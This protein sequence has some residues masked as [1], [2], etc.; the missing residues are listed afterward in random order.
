MKSLFEIA[1][2]NDLIEKEDYGID[3]RTFRS[4]RKSQL[5]IDPNLTTELIEGHSGMRMVERPDSPSKEPLLKKRRLNFHSVPV[6]DRMSLD[7]FMPFFL[8]KENVEALLR[9]EGSF[10]ALEEK[11]HAPVILISYF[12]KRAN[13]MSRRRIREIQAE[14]NWGEE[15]DS[16]L[17]SLDYL[18]EIIKFC[19]EERET[20]V[21]ELL[22]ESVVEF[23][24]FALPEV[25]SSFVILDRP[26]ELSQVIL[27]AGRR[28]GFETTTFHNVLF[29]FLRNIPPPFVS[30]T[31]GP[32]V[33]H[34]KPVR[35]LIFERLLA[36]NAEEALILL[37][38]EQL[39]EPKHFNTLLFNGLLGL[40]CR[41]PSSL[42]RAFVFDRKRFVDLLEVGVRYPDDVL[43]L[44]YRL[45]NDI[46]SEQNFELLVAYLGNV[47]YGENGE[48]LLSARN[49]LNVCL[50]S[51]ILAHVV[52]KKYPRKKI[53]IRDIIDYSR[54]TMIKMLNMPY[55]SCKYLVTTP[56]R[57][58]TTF[59]HYLLNSDFSDI[60][61]LRII[62]VIVES[63]WNPPRLPTSD[64]HL[65]RYTL[66]RMFATTLAAKYA[67]IRVINSPRFFS[68]V[69][70]VNACFG[71]FI[72]ALFLIL[73][74]QQLPEDF[75]SISSSIFVFAFQTIPPLMIIVILNRLSLL[76]NCLLASERM[77]MIVALVIINIQLVLPVSK[78]DDSR[79]LV[80]NMFVPLFFFQLKRAIDHMTAFRGIG[81]PIRL[82]LYLLPLLAGYFA[83]IFVLLANF[84]FLFNRMFIEIRNNE[85]NSFY[86]FYEGVFFLF[87]LVFGAIALVKP[88]FVD[89][90]IVLQNI[91]IICMGIFGNIM[92]INLLAAYTIS[93][94][95]KIKEKAQYFFLKQIYT[96]C[97][98]YNNLTY[99]QLSEIPVVLGFVF[100]PIF[101]IIRYMRP[102]LASPRLVAY[103]LIMMPTT[104]AIFWIRSIFTIPELYLDGWSEI[105]SDK[106]IRNR[107]KI[108]KL[109]FWT[110]FGIPIIFWRT[111]KDYRVFVSE[112]FAPSLANPDN[113]ATREEKL[114]RKA[115]FLYS[116][117]PI[118]QEVL[119]FTKTISPQELTEILFPKYLEAS[120]SPIKITVTS[121]DKPEGQIETPRGLFLLSSNQRTLDSIPRGVTRHWL[122]KFLKN[123]S[124]REVNLQLLQRTIKNYS[125]FPEPP[126]AHRINF[127]FPA[128]MSSLQEPG[129]ILAECV[130]VAAKL[131]LLIAEKIKKKV[132]RKIKESTSKYEIARTLNTLPKVPSLKRRKSQ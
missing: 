8:G 38:T 24:V 5:R 114:R 62:Q 29:T 17:S 113:H 36:L 91:A 31:L 96:N 40:V 26:L 28:L 57:T 86:D 9:S 100:L 14:R 115:N 120:K 46:N 27:K 47:L 72:E 112:L 16:L 2:N 1:E 109:V 52:R 22:L 129:R 85:I 88:P 99:K 11:L 23:G 131:E 73:L 76:I 6:E 18:R 128:V 19:L 121:P 94:M 119:K 101:P 49:P 102:H 90:F 107:K 56:D 103:I 58:K 84:T 104:F 117:L 80:S 20:E 79:I 95:E 82:I 124:F 69:A 78:M 32:L 10:S 65:R 106:L 93:R 116:C 98:E 7:L 70:I 3:N 30:P 110:L 61:Y 132:S 41:L 75:E 89:S 63:F 55:K 51:L 68:M 77:V 111:I 25:I 53:K 83:V 50:L 54:N 15:K 87:E 42:L 4:L 92:I 45:R 74:D 44:L 81:F 64:E 122:S 126:H 127:M 118:I 33:V 130:H 48:H 66:H 59:L 43:A 97:D 108:E 125:R 12:L 105:W 60:T 37:G 35:D 71:M 21:Y 67:Y 34:L 13:P 123:F 39:V